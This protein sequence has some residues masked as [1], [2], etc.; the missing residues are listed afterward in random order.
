[1]LASASL[2]VSLLAFGAY[3]LVVLTDCPCALCSVL[4]MFKQLRSR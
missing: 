2:L 3:L 4:S 1:M